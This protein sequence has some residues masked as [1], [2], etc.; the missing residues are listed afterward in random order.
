MA[1][2]SEVMNNYPDG[3]IFF[4]GAKSGS[5]FFYIG[6]KYRWNRIGSSIDLYHMKNHEKI[7][8]SYPR[9]VRMHKK[10]IKD[11]REGRLNVVAPNKTIEKHKRDIATLERL[12]E[13]RKE[14]VKNYIPIY[15]RNIMYCF[16]KM[17]RGVAIIIPGVEAGR[18]WFKEEF[19]NDYSYRYD[20][21]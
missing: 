5:S 9:H 7:L 2:I 16:E 19:D 3:T 10:K 14:Y 11:I 8:K 1:T 17:L 20:V 4:V 12:C 21:M 13:E 18:Y 15:K 6:D